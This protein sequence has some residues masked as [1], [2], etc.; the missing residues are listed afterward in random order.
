MEIKKL[1]Q[2]IGDLSK[3]KFKQKNFFLSNESNYINHTFYTELNKKLQ[4]YGLISTS[5][6]GIKIKNLIRPENSLKFRVLY[7]KY[8]DHI[9][10]QLEDIR[11]PGKTE[12]KDAK[13]TIFLILTTWPKIKVGSKEKMSYQVADEIRIVGLQNYNIYEKLNPIEINIDNSEIQENYQDMVPNDINIALLFI[14]YELVHPLYKIE[15]WFS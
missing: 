12:T 1:V 7:N 2:K 15:M 5:A 9:V 14:V 13:V 3:I 11:K 4:I 8:M 6:I 10:L